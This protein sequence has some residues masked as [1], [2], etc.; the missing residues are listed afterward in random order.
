MAKQEIRKIRIFLTYQ[1]CQSVLVLHHCMAAL[2]S[3]VAPGIILQC[4]LAMAYVVVGSHDEAG[5]HELHDHMQI[6]PG[7]LAVSVDDL[8]NPLRLCRR[9]INPSINLVALVE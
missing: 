7:M 4:G 1:F 8:D 2:V 9:D 5:V 3:P 6:T